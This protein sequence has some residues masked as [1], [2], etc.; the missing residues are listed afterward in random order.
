MRHNVLL[1]CVNVSARSVLEPPL[2]ELV[3]EENAGWKKGGG[4]VTL[5]AAATEYFC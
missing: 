5:R 4:R 1:K 3:Q 2:L